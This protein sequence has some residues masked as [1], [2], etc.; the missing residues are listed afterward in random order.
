MDVR[1]L[2]KDHRHLRVDR[3]RGLFRAKGVSSQVAGAKS[4]EGQRKVLILT[5][6]GTV[7]AATSLDFD[8]ILF[9]FPMHFISFPQLLAS[10]AGF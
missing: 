10:F 4:I 8:E 7:L 1:R 9:K 5:I 2:S 3:A 6:A